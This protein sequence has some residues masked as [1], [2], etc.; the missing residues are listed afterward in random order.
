MA[1]D[2]PFERGALGQHGA[3]VILADLLQQA[4]LHEQG[5]HREVADHV[6]GDR[7]EH[8]HE[9]VFGLV[10][11]GHFGE[12]LRGEA[13]YG[14]DVPQALRRTREKHLQQHAERERGDGIADEHQHAAGGVEP[15]TVPD[16][17]CYA[18][19]DAHQVGQEEAG[20]S[21]YQRDR[22][23]LDDELQDGLVRVF[24]GID[25]HADTVGDQ[26]FPVA[27]Q[28]R[29]V[30]TEMF[31]QGLALIRRDAA[32]S[33]GRGRIDGGIA[34]P[35]HRHDRL[36]HRATRDELAQGETGKG[37]A[38][39]GR[40]HQQ[41]PPDDVVGAFHCCILKRSWGQSKNSGEFLTLTP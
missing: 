9:Q 7:Q 4:V 28:Q 29:P 14:E 24:I 31:L 18:Q 10:R 11:A 3:H 21:E 16:G 6:T 41:Q 12:V 19:R 32:R 40:D 26:P 20:E 5:E 27:L 37:N 38:D 17:L 8:V 35:A 15:G 25:R 34:D 1:P 22:E 23:A 36:L 33:C 39:E 2:G 30:E 13:T